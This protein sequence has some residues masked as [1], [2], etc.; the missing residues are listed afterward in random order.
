MDAYERLLSNVLGEGDSSS[1]DETPPKNEIDQTNSETRRPQMLRFVQAGLKKTEGE[2]AVKHNIR[3]KMHAVI[4]V[5]GLIDTAVKSSPE[6][7]LAWTGV[8]FA[9]Q[10]SVATDCGLPTLLTC[11]EILA[12]PIGES[13]ANRE[14]IAHVVSRM[15]WYWNLSSLLLEEHQSDKAA[16]LRGELEKH[17]IGLYKKLLAYQMTSACSYYRNRGVVF[18]RDMIKLDDWENTL[19]SIKN[20]ENTVRQDVTTYNTE[21]IK[22]HLEGLH[23]AAVSRRAMLHDIYIAVQDQTATLREMQQEGKNEECLKALRVRDPRGDRKR[24]EDTKGGLFRDSSNWIL[25][26]EDFK[27][28]RDNDETRLLWITGDPGKGKTML[29]IAIIDELEKLAPQGPSASIALSYF[30][31]QGTNDA[32]NDATAVVKGLVFLLG[33]KYP[34]LIS[35]LRK[36]YDNAGSNLFTDENAFF[37]LSEVLEGMLLD[38]NLSRA[39][40]VVDALDE[41]ETDLQRLLKF[42]VRSA[43]ASPRVSWIVSSLI[44]PTSSSS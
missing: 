26:H 34:S 2:D 25:Q 18:L 29:V 44:G 27:R 20:A 33:D 19:Q 15:D 7:A 24:I 10:V 37:A 35:Y 16:G 5:K 22:T 21:K 43:S 38:A 9:L 11:P 28:W 32:L 8:C 40:I 17:V 23:D 12:N 42:I 41:C 13:A 6:A 4:S 3:G 36:R 39:Y 1:A 31:C 30:F 14:G